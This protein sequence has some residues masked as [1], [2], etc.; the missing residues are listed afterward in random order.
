MKKIALSLVLLI[1]AI[2][3]PAVGQVPLYQPYA[4]P[5]TEAEKRRILLPIVRAATDCIAQRHPR[6][7]ER[8]LTRIVLKSCLCYRGSLVAVHQRA[9]ACRDGARPAT[10]RRDR[11]SLVKGA[12]K[13]DLPRAV[14]T[15]IRSEMERRITAAEQAEAARRAEV[16]RA[17]TKKR[18]E[19]DRLER[20]ANTLRDRMYE[21]AEN[22]LGKLVRSSETAEVLTTAAMSI[23][24]RE[25]DGAL[26]AH[27]ELA[28][29]QATYSEAEANGLRERLRG[30]ARETILADAVKLRAEAN[31][32]P[33]RPKSNSPDPATPVGRA[34]PEST[35]LTATTLV[36]SPELSKCLGAVNTVQQGKLVERAKLVE[37]ML[38]LCRPEI[39]T[40][41]RAAFLK[42]PSV[43]LQQARESALKAAAEAAEAMV[44]GT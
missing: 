1:S 25:V 38:D 29:A 2:A 11:H 42:E 15:R 7:P 23:C 16:A 43:P 19:V 22:E 24:R 20:V 13:D 10:R 12:Y 41:A 8:R 18:E 33:A 39:E 26:N 35:P 36:I 14:T 5:L 3:D 28:R 4:A 6:S 31:S 34:Q 17:E 37:A 21:C 27:V 32:A 40:M 30:G 44:D 9:C